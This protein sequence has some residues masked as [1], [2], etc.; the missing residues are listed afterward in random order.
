MNRV[1]VNKLVT[2]PNLIATGIL[3]G[4]IGLGLGIYNTYTFSTFGNLA[5][6]QLSAQETIDG[7]CYLWVKSSGIAPIC[8][9]IEPYNSY[10]Y[11]PTTP[12]S[13]CSP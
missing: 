11:S 12:N 3:S 4:F 8:Y 9:A 7:D 13:D 1:L 10:C 5:L 2:R 6:L